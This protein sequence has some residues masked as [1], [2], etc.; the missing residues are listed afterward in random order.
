MRDEHTPIEQPSQQPPGYGHGQEK[1]NVEQVLRLADNHAGR[2]GEVV[3]PRQR[4][5]VEAVEEVAESTGTAEKT[6]EAGSS[7]IAESDVKD[8]KAET[9]EDPDDDYEIELF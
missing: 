2:G 5:H 7:D 6:E 4:H 1:N 9:E 8:E 3:Q